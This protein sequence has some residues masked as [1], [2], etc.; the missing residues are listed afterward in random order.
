[1]AGPIH[2][3][4]VAAE[5]KR[6]REGVGV[7]G[8]EVAAA[9]GWSQPKVSRI[10]NARIAVSTRDL[11]TLL[12]YYGV[13]EEVRAELLTMTAGDEGIGGAW[14]V[15]AGGVT[16]RQGEVAAIETRVRSI[17]QYYPLMVPGQLQSPEYALAYTRSGGWPN[18]EAIVAR[19]M[20]RQELLRSH[21]APT[22]T[23]LLD[24]RAFLAWPGSRDMV[25]SQLAYLRTRAELPNVTVRIIPLGVDR[26][27]SAMV[28]FTLYDFRTESS[29]RVVYVESQTADLYLSA[30]ADVE[31]YSGVFDALAADALTHDESIEHLASLA[32]YVE[33]LED[34]RSTDGR[35]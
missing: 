9:L 24:A 11:A 22:Y 20:S 35:P 6:I 17:Q 27:A 21:D 28:P 14:L 3:E 25:L 12:H 5:L 23:A 10:E 2:R 1:M 34:P 30:P 16:R 32:R 33:D 8:E 26:T 19:R 18:P 29:P 7:S 15:R 13:P 4:R 31:A